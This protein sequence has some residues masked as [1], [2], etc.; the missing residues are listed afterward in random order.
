MNKMEVLPTTTEDISVKNEFAPNFLTEYTPANVRSPLLAVDYVVDCFKYAD[1]PLLEL[2]NQ[3]NDIMI[4]YNLNYNFKNPRPTPELA[5]ISWMN[6]CWYR[7]EKKRTAAK[8]VNV[9]ITYEEQVRTISFYN[10]RGYNMKAELGENIFTDNDMQLSTVLLL[11]TMVNAMR[12]E[13]KAAMHPL[14]RLTF[15]EASVR[16]LSDMFNVDE[17]SAVKIANLATVRKSHQFADVTNYYKPELAI[18]VTIAGVFGTKRVDDITKGI[19]KKSIKKIIK[20]CKVDIDE[21]RMLDYLECISTG[22]LDFEPEAIYRAWRENRNRGLNLPR[23]S[24]ISGVTMSHKVRPNS[25]ASMGGDFEQ[26][27]DNDDEALGG[28]GQ[29]SKDETLFEQPTPAELAKWRQMASTFNNQMQ[30]QPTES[31]ENPV[32]RP[33]RVKGQGQQQPSTGGKGNA[34]GGKNF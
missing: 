23:Q 12:K 31:V 8:K 34:K 25:G 3:R 28:Y 19:A 1:C 24:T 14:S 26:F 9:K 27:N 5:F 7:D 11:N 15:P 22:V 18:A 32:L 29:S 10:L 2:Y 21:R 16:A 33:E 17:N 20:A 6:S 13:G 30:P 4:D